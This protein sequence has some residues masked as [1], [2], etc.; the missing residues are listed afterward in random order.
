MVAKTKS[1]K[2][3]VAEYIC[4]TP[5]DVQDLPVNDGPGSIALIVSNATVYILNGQKEW[6]VLGGDE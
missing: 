5:A 4:D 2:F 3:G 1:D 6:K